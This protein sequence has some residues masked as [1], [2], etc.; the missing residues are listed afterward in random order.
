MSGPDKAVPKVWSGRRSLPRK[1]EISVQCWRSGILRV[2]EKG[3]RTF[4][5]GGPLGKALSYP[6]RGP[7]HQPLALQNLNQKAPRSPANPSKN[8]RVQS[9]RARKR[10]TAPT[11]PRF[12]FRPSGSASAETALRGEKGRVAARAAQAHRGRLLWRCLAP[13]T[14][15]CC[16]WRKSTW[17]SACRWARRALL[18]L[19][20]GRTVRGG[21]FVCGGGFRPAR[22]RRVPGGDIGRSSVPS[23]RPPGRVGARR[24]VCERAVGDGLARPC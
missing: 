7:S 22:A 2:V 3:G 18:S 24:T 15:I 9:P 19:R 8:G 20:R 1:G 11:S 14:G 16:S 12:R 17:S 21:G 13:W 23:P 6:Q 5:V 10:G 4:Q